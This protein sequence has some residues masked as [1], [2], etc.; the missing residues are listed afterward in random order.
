MVQNLKQHLI[1]FLFFLQD[2][3]QCF[4]IFKL[5]ELKGVNVSEERGSA[6]CDPPSSEQDNSRGLTRV[7]AG[8]LFIITHIV[9]CK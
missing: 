7:P 6:G 5:Q 9:L 8:T 4:A 3:A 1:L 2:V